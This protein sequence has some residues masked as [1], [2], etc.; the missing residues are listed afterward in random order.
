MR[1]AMHGAMLG[2]CS[3]QCT[4][5]TQQT[6]LTQRIQDSSENTYV[7]D[8]PTPVDNE[9]SR[10][11]KKRRLTG[12]ELLAEVRWLLDGGV[13]PLMVCTVLGK[14]LDAVEITARRYGQADIARV[15]AA[16]SFAERTRKQQAPGRRAA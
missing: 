13:H 9:V 3:E 1:E 2:G 10:V 11:V 14:S 5:R 4:Q 16:A 6:Q 12:V 15:F 7:P 8:A